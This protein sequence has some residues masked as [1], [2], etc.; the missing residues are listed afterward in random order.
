MDWESHPTLSAPYVIASAADP[1]TKT[2]AFAGPELKAHIKRLFEGEVRSLAPPV[3]AA[4]VAPRPQSSLSAFICGDAANA[5][6][7]VDATIEAELK[8]FYAAAGQLNVADVP[9]EWWVTR[10]TLYPTV[11]KVFCKFA[12]VQGATAVAERLFSSTG[13]L[14][15]R[16]RCR[17]KPENMSTVVFCQKNGKELNVIS[18]E[19]ELEP[20]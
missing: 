4:V 20:L 8:S 19:D 5:G 6:V 18:G 7:A 10:K 13:I 15:E 2:L 14:H 16:K 9:S 12:H 11:Y 3:A 17:W 1:R